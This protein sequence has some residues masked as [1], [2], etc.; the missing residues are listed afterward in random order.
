[1]CYYITHQ[2]GVKA[3]FLRQRDPENATPASVNYIEKSIK[4]IMVIIM[5]DT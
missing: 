2:V 5:C 3:S 4:M 1:M